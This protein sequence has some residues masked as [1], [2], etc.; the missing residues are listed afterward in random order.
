MLENDACRG[1]C[2]R[3]IFSFS[4]TD[5]AAEGAGS[6]EGRTCLRRG[7][8]AIRLYEGALPRDDEKHDATANVVRACESVESGTSI[9]EHGVN[10]PDID[11]SPGDPGERA[12]KTP[13]RG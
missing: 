5:R 3:D 7:E 12:H 9:D 1:D 4:Q 10:P 13:S 2:S 6:S 8:V 11:G